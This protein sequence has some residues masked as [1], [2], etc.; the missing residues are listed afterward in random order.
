VWVLKHWDYC[1]GFSNSR[2]LCELSEWVQVLGES[3]RALLVIASVLADVSGWC[4]IERVRP[5][6]AVPDAVLTLEWPEDE[7]CEFERGVA[8]HGCHEELLFHGSAGILIV[9]SLVWSVCSQARRG[10]LY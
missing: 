8:A 2:N 5:G 10:I 7:N 9:A 3:V 6:A 1:I 4:A